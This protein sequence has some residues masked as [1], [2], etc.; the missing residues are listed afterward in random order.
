[1][2][3]RN[4]I[5]IILATFDGKPIYCARCGTQVHEEHEVEGYPY[6]CPEH[7]ENLYT[8]ETTLKEVQI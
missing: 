4:D 5:K 7:D 1:M 8:F 6:Y 2:A 3:N